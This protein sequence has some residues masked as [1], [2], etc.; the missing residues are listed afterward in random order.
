[1][2]TN[3]RHALLCTSAAL[4]MLAG[5]P[6][7]AETDVAGVTA[8]VN[9]QATAFDASGKPRLISLGDAVIRNHRIE[10]SGEGTEAGRSS[11]A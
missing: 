8:A 7:L 1:M 11:P 10:T 5:A 4:L 3:T 2:K 9:P 6:A